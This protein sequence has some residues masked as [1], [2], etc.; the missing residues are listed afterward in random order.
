MIKFLSF[1]F[2]IFLSTNIFS[3]LSNIEI[4]LNI[5]KLD[6]FP[7]KLFNEE[8]LSYEGFS[9]EYSSFLIREEDFIKIEFTSNI[10]DLQVISYKVNLI[11]RGDCYNSKVYIGN[12]IPNDILQN[13]K[14]KKFK[15]QFEFV[16]ISSFVVINIKTQE[17]F[18]LK[19]EHFSIRFE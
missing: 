11:F 19:D 18:K 17:I 8:T 9:S 4:K 6:S 3:Q 12:K 16:A 14:Y 10:S 7:T 1:T 2:V 5:P 13:E 15:S